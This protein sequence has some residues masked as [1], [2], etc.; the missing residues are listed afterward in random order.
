MYCPKC[1]KYVEDGDRFC[2]S[3]GAPVQRCAYTGPEQS[4]ARSTPRSNRNYRM[5]GYRPKEDARLVS[6]LLGL[7]LNVIGLLIAVVIYNGSKREF[8][9]DPTGYALM[10]ALIGIVMEFVL[11]YVIFFVILGM[12]FTLTGA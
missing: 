3:C 9:E 5:D 4:T 7:F 8:E 11:A 10:W 1:G 2:P 6:F 12:A